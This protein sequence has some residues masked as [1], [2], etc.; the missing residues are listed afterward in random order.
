MRLRLF[1]S[2]GV[3]IALISI[4]LCQGCA[5]KEIQGEVNLLRAQV[6]VI[7]FKQKLEQSYPDGNASM[8]AVGVAEAQDGT[9]ENFKIIAP[10]FYRY[11]RHNKKITVTSI[12]KKLVSLLENSKSITG[13]ITVSIDTGGALER[14]RHDFTFSYQ[15]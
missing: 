2:A 4:V 15:K 12:D 13:E 10:A 14:R 1:L 6:Q 7:V 3:V 8:T 5:R 11:D 9:R